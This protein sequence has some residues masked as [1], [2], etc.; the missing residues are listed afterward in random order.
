MSKGRLIAFA[1]AI[2]G[3]SV[4]F[5]LAAREYMW[6]AFG[7]AQGP[8]PP[9]RVVA[10]QPPYTLIE[11]E[12]LTKPRPLGALVL[13]ADVVLADGQRFRL[14]GVRLLRPVT[15]AD[16]FPHEVGR[17]RLATVDV[18][19]LAPDA[20]S[21]RI[22]FRAQNFAFCG[23][24]RGAVPKYRREDLGVHLV[25]HGLALPTLEVLAE[26]PAYARELGGALIHGNLDPQVTA[27]D[28]DAAAIGQAMMD[29][30]FTG[31]PRDAIWAQRR[32]AN[33]LALSGAPTTFAPPRQ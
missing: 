27:G 9:P 3:A 29:G 19:P 14:A 17:A 21:T 13:P 15:L 11:N 12:P 6:R 30:R 5:A 16:A 26:D 7:A 8:A 10:P 20:A 32:G 4:V 23:N 22:D 25:A 31:D 1:V 18:E 28:K 2:T 24:T 33:L